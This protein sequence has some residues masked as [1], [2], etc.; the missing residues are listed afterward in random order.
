MILAEKI[1][2]LRKKNGWS[3]E[4]L[5]YQMNVSRQ[6]V[7]KWESGTSI[8]DLERILKLSQVFGVSTDYLLKEEIEVEQTIV[9]LESDYDDALKSV[10]LEEANNFMELK[11]SAA[12]K[13]AIAAAAYILSPVLLIFLEGLSQFKGHII[14]ENMAGGFGIVILLLIVGLATVFFVLHEMKMEHYQYLDKE[15]F[16]LEYGV[17]GIVRKRMEEYEG[18]H[19]IF[20]M[21]GVFLCIIC[22]VP[23]MVAAAFDSSNFIYIMCVDILLIIVACA[24]FLFVVSGEKKECFQMLLQEGEYTA[25]KKLEKKKTEH[26]PVIYWCIITAVYLGISFYTYNWSRTWIIWPCAGIMYAAVQAF[27]AALKNKEE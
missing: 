9:S 21:T 14:S 12:K 6:S 23:L 16:R 24:V 10:T 15:I 8:P 26:L 3:Q 1:A 7:S 19:R 27:A 17:E 2:A 13:V 4:E 25:A 11:I 5:A 18:T 22:V 20:T